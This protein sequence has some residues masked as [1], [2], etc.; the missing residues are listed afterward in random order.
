M[1]TKRMGRLRRRPTLFAV[2]V[3]KQ[4]GPFYVRG[5]PTADAP[6]CW[7]TDRSRQSCGFMTA[8][9]P[10][11]RVELKKARPVATNQRAAK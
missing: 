2:L 5:S 7:Q 11:K 4:E 6:P 1:F 3:R 10:L 9:L 8:R